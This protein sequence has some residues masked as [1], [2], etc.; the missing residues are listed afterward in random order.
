MNINKLLGVRYPIIQGGMA[1]MTN[2]QFAAAL[3]NAGVL[4]TIGAGGMKPDTLKEEIAICRSKT[5]KPFAVNLIMF[6][7]DIEEMVDVV[8][9]AKV[10][11]VI[12]GAASPAPF[13]EK[14]EAAGVKVIPV[15]SSP[16]QIKRLDKLNVLAYIVEGMEAGG[17]IG[18]MTSMTLIYQAR[19]TTDKPV[20][21]A[22]GIGSGAQMLAAEVLGADGVQIGT[23]FLFTKESPTH[24][25]YKNALINATA[26]R[27]TQIGYI[28]GRPM[29]VLKNAMAREFL[30]LEKEEENKELLETFTLGRLKKAVVEG[31]VQQGSVMC[32]YT[33]AQFDKI[34]SAQE[35]VDRLVGEYKKAKEKI[36]AGA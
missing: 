1:N 15:V 22:G 16:I 19:Q 12:A 34:C 25:N 18:E 4:G 27:V 23:A 32:G 11:F 20:I 30:R 21:A 2:G 7:R 33:V 6:R 5:D 36:K 9:E 35:M 13:M 8:C 10:P 3:S 29:R 28:N 17:H 24:E 14:F 26:T 31:D